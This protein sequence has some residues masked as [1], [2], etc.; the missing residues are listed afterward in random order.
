MPRQSLPQIYYQNACID[1]IRTETIMNK[2]SMSGD[3]ILGYEMSHN[4]D[5]DTEQEFC[6]AEQYLKLTGTE[7]SHKFV[8]DIDGVIA[9]IRHDLDYGK[10]EPNRRMIEV[11]NRLYEA[12]NRIVLFTAR[13]YVS[14]IDWEKT[15]REQMSGW[16]IKYHEL[17]FGKPDADFYIDDKSL[18]MDALYKWL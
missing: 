9:Q 2:N 17:H 3:V 18:S 11:I 14:G 10:A 16:G 6:E 7:R 4:F 12:G 1:V 13:G 8:F 5:I 15:T